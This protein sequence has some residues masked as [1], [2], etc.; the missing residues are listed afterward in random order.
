VDG[1][2]ERERELRRRG[3]E[4]RVL[5]AR[6]WNEGGKD[7]P[8]KPRS[9]EDVVGL[10][11]WGTHPAL[12]LYR[13]GPLWRALGEAWDV[14]DIHEE[15]FA[16]S[17]AEVLLLRALRRQRAPYVLY[18]AQNIRK[19]YPI[20][21]RWLE[22]WSLR[23][24]AGVSVCNVEAGRIVEDKGLRGQSS[25]IPLGTDLS[26]FSPAAGNS[27]RD[28]DR[29]TVGYVGRLAAHKGVRELIDAVA[30]DERLILRIAGSGPDEVELRARAA[31]RAPTRISFVGALEQ[32]ALP[33]FYRSLDV[34][35]VPSL[36]TRTWVEQFGRVAVEAMACGTPVVASDS[37]ALPEVVGQGGIVVPAGDV[38]ALG[39]ALA[40][41][42]L[43]H[44]RLAAIGAAAVEQTRG[45]GWSRVADDYLDLYQ[46]VLP[47]RPSSDPSSPTERQVQILVVAYGAPGLLRSALR[48]VRHEAVLVVDN[49]SS[50]EVRA[51]CD[52]LGISY[53]DMGWNA[54]FAS[55]VNAGL[56]RLAPV[57]D[58]LL[59]NPDAVIEPDGI[60]ALQAA[61][62]ADPRIAS[63]G[64]IQV[65]PSGAS[66]RVAWPYPSPAGSWVDAFGL[67]R[68]RTSEDF[69][70]GSVLM[71]RSEALEQVGPFDE[72]FFLYA[73]ETDWAYRASAIGWRHSVVPS[74]RALHVGA[75]TSTDLLRREAHFHA[76]QERYLRKHYGVVG[77]QIAR[78]AQLF[79]SS[80]R[81]LLPGERG[82]LA[83]NRLGLYARGPI[84][85][86]HLYVSK[87]DPRVHVTRSGSG[88]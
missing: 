17:T 60:R 25:L 2:R 3:H 10:S 49:S 38:A 70:I 27:P 36:T 83:R 64:P 48:P 79:G 68:L 30:G 54:G 59:L 41:L 34:L 16:L 8:L 20:P 58:V 87:Q 40:D 78:T 52:E 86:E 32:P 45:M 57:S 82:R 4:V 77:W 43:D 84:V 66:E 85:A 31:E 35:A 42:G 24:A 72:R 74:V 39:A 88:A 61:M 69:V 62:L 56:H 44:Q 75:G 67:G 51:V 37:G 29:A 14:I 28:P 1:W 73:E 80:V 12:F 63:V 19:R 53:V 47:P 18:S 33:G 55:A 7:V 22:A 5:S 50:S 46:R 6:R 11:T 15:P 23:H 9:G 71:L 21:F 26:L 13:P 81:S 76:S 65:G